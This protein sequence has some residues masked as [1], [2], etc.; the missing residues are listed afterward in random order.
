MSVVDRQYGWSVAAAGFARMW[1]GSVPFLTVSVVNAI[2]QASL[3]GLPLFW[4]AWGMSAAV[5]LITF[6]LMAHI[7]DRSVYRRSRVG[8]LR[9]ARLTV[10]AVWVAGWT[11]VINVGLAFYFWPGL[12]LLALTPFIPVA[13]AAGVGNPLGA[14]F[15]AIRSRPV[16][17]LLTL[18]L[19]FLVILAVWLAAALNAFFIRGWIASFSSWLIIGLVAACLLTSWAALYRSTPPGVLQDDA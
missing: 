19:S 3:V 2:I 17:Y 8:D 9:G 6:A 16:R 13:A 4:L 15:A 1:R 10:F 14:N 7:A 12:L 18:A 11:I 5:L